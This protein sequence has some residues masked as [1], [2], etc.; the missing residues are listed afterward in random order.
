MFIS[1]LHSIFA[2]AG[3]C[4]DAR[5]GRPTGDTRTPGRPRIEGGRLACQCSVMSLDQGASAC[6]ERAASAI[7]CS[8]VGSRR[9]F[10]LSRRYSTED[11]RHAGC[12]ISACVGAGPGEKMYKRIYT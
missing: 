12:A 7:H 4:P 5:A 3:R 9:W 10:S 6:M 1:P 2:Q 8:P 11:L